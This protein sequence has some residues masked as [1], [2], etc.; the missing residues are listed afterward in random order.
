MR[1]A[2]GVEAARM[3]VGKRTG[4]LSLRDVVTPSDGSAGRGRGAYAPVAT[5]ISDHHL[6]KSLLG[7]RPRSPMSAIDPHAF[8]AACKAPANSRARAADAWTSAGG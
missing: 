2:V 5:A 4:G 1:D 8:W 6:G 7:I 3:P